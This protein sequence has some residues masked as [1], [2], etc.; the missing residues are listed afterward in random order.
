MAQG[1]CNDSETMRH[2]LLMY[3]NT[4]GFPN[5]CRLTVIATWW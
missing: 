5:V 2:V 4:L 3:Y 1:A